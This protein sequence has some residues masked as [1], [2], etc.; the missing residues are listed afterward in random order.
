MPLSV[1]ILMT[2]YS[3]AQYRPDG[4]AEEHWYV[5]WA[6]LHRFYFMLV[7]ASLWLSVAQLKL[8]YVHY[9]RAA[10]DNMFMCDY[11]LSTALVVAMQTITPQEIVSSSVVPALSSATATPLPVSGG[12]TSVTSPDKKAEGFKG[13]GGKGSDRFA[14]TGSRR[15]R[16][17]SPVRSSGYPPRS[18]VCEAFNFERRGCSGG[19]RKLHRC[20]KCNGRDHGQRACREGA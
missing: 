17:R 12:L 3:P 1:S 9:M 18:E 8:V 20:L 10:A 19:C 6:D 4:D 5:T 14:N 2:E 16:S 11:N 7:E 15:S 13:K